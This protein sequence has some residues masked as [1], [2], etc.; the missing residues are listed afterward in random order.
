MGNM[1]PRMLGYCAS[2]SPLAYFTQD[3][4]STS[5]W[6][7]GAYGASRRAPLSLQPRREAPASLLY[8]PACS[9]EGRALAA[10]AHQP[11]CK[12]RRDTPPQDDESGEGPGEPPQGEPVSSQPQGAA[13]P[14]FHMWKKLQCQKEGGRCGFP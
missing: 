13:V 14:G 2:S 8:Q 11:P 4:L 12:A 9:G 5:A 6:E 7:S 3:S 1:K 10:A